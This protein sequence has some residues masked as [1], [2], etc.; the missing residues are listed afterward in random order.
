MF[1]RDVINFSQPYLSLEIPLHFLGISSELS[2]REV[3][4]TKVESRSRFNKIL[5]AV[6]NNFKRV[7]SKYS[8]HY[9]LNKSEVNILFNS[10]PFLGLIFFNRKKFSDSYYVN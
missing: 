2:N 1:G 8:L 5:I 9:A 4:Q 6:T 3:D 10:L 7:S